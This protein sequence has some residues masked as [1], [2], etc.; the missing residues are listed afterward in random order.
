MHK[1]VFLETFL[2]TEILELSLVAYRGK[3]ALPATDV[4]LTI[5]AHLETLLVIL[6]THVRAKLFDVTTESGLIMSII[7][8]SKSCSLS[9]PD[10][11]FA[12]TG[13]LYFFVAGGTFRHASLILG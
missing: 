5:T 3:E 4:L 12:K 6:Q 8:L 9:L 2:L 13:S 11:I 7:T 1:L 10:T